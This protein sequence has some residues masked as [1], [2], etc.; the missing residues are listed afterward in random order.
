LQIQ[1]QSVDASEV[2][3]LSGHSMGAAWATLINNMLVKQGRL[4][5]KRVLVTSGT[6]LATLKYYSA[7][8]IDDFGQFGHLL[9][10]IEDG[11]K[12]LTDL[13]MVRKTQNEARLPPTTLPQ[14]AYACRTQANSFQCIDPQP[15]T[16]SIEDSIQAVESRGV[17]PKIAMIHEFRFYKACFLACIPYFESRNVEFKPNVDSYIMYA[18]SRDA[19]MDVTDESPSS[20]PRLTMSA[21]YEFPNEHLHRPGWRHGRMRTKSKSA[22]EIKEIVKATISELRPTEQETVSDWRQRL[23]SAV[24]DKIT[25]DPEY[26]AT[27]A[28]AG[29]NWFTDMTQ[30]AFDNY[31]ELQE[32]S[33]D[34]LLHNYQIKPQTRKKP[35]AAN[36]DILKDV[37]AWVL[38]RVRKDGTESFAE[39][40][41][42]VSDEVKSRLRIEGYAAPQGD[43][44]QRQWFV[45]QVKQGYER[46]H[47]AS[48]KD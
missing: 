18:A 8:Q 3:I 26:L 2:I 38:G 39:F 6:P 37:V 28:W 33:L 47:S 4:P 9:L 14:F 34:N 44:F 36:A 25:S 29:R 21:Q 5:D 1:I 46:E 19:M 22:E 31:D 11:S 43:L 42:R 20:A 27:T 32:T 13:E 40:L 7:F 45:R 16:F 23:F 15:D 48:G 17:N 10:A 41:A 35:P 24:I 30:I 12:V